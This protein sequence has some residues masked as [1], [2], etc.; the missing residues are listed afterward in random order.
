MELPIWVWFAFIG[1]VLGML[2][3]DLGVFNRKAHVVSVREAGIW[4]TVWVSLGLAFAA[5]VYFWQGPQKG[6]E[7][8]TGYV[9][10]YSLAVD[11]IFVF[12]MVFAYFG[13]PAIYR[14]RVLFWGIIG[15][16]LMR[17]AM[18]LLG[19]EL[20]ERFHWIL[21]VFGAFLVFT[22]IKMFTQR[23][24]DEA[25]DLEANPVIRFAR[26]LLR[27]SPEY[28]GQKFFTV[29]NGVR[30]A[31]PLFLV[32]IFIEFTDLIFA[33]DSIPAIFAITTDPFI[34]FTSNVMAI[35]GLRSLYFLLAHVVD[36]FIYLKTG[37]SVILTF[38]GVKLLLIDV[39]KIPTT[40]SLSVIVSVLT[41]SVL[42]SLWAT[43]KGG[44]REVPAEEH[45]RLVGEVERQG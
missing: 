18:I 41:V 25:V 13:V 6:I 27:V 37:L 10:E 20:I 22:G 38:I 23:G 2:A 9:V 21:Y 31:T 8:L 30:M 45:E 5:L 32:L 39:Y 35:L 29:R 24:D 42:A 26:R 15:A 7:W 4:T 12:V 11:N 14:H 19:V 28:D 44:P 36:R 16:L 40:V 33:V 3:L 17:G 34:V 43:R 1:F